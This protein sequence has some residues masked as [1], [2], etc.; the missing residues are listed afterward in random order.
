MPPKPLEA[1]TQALL[2]DGPAL[3]F[4][5]AEF[6]TRSSETQRGRLLVAGALAVAEKGYA[7]A[8][9]SDIVAAAGV[10]RTAFYEH[11]DG[12]EDCLVEAYR[13]SVTI[14]L[15][16]M[17]AAATDAATGGWRAAL[18]AGVRSVF[19]TI[20]EHPAIARATYVELAGAGARGLSA[21]REGNDRFAAQIAALAD[22]VRRMDPSMPSADPRLVRL[23]ISGLELQVAYAI[24]EDRLDE[25]DA[26]ADVALAAL[27]AL[28][29]P[30]G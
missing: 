5:A 2:A 8:T 12:K 21:R 18:T 17:A 15:E 20:R 25:L 23:V 30:A 27:S 9:V 22:A 29:N 6:L 24:N 1:D 11:F 28:F 14:T 13:A 26:L 7:R 4:S 16:R 10:S 19:E 3:G